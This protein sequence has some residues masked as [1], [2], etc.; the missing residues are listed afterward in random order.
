MSQFIFPYK[1]IYPN[2]DGDAFVAPSASVI[3]DVE[4]SKGANVWYNCVLRGDVNDI[5]I[6]VNTNIQDATVIHVTTDFAGTIVGDNVT[7]GHSAVLHAC[8]IEDHGFVGMKSCV[9]DGAVVEEFGMLAAG[10]LL[11]PG[12]CVPKGE[13]WSGSPARYMRDLTDREIDYIKWSAPHYV[14][15]GREHRKCVFGGASA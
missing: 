15:L 7:V 2:I 14:E 8:I 6:G 5:R 12:K 9:M 11:T 13:L 3:G 1:G 10:S 4:I